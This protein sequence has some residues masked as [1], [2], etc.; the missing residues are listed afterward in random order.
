MHLLLER[1]PKGQGEWG[2]VH[3]P[4]FLPRLVRTTPLSSADCFISQCD[5]LQFIVPWTRDTEL[6]DPT[7]STP[8]VLPLLNSGYLWVV[9]DLADSNGWGLRRCISHHVPGPARSGTQLWKIPPDGYSH[10]N[11]GF[12]LALPPSLFFVYISFTTV[13]G[14]EF[15]LHTKWG[16]AQSKVHKIQKPV[17]QVLL[18]A[19]SL[20]LFFFCGKNLRGRIP[21]VEAL[22]E[23][24][25]N[26]CKHDYGAF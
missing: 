1:A 20:S 25:Q 21:W 15:T 22:R 12:F 16:P 9:R 6:F 23:V 7:Y 13:R 17:E 19:H 18:S 14:P 26:I 2:S 5:I 24:L 4:L 3:C 10:C 8:L 11:Q